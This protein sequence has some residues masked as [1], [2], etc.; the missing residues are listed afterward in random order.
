M[1]D[2]PLSPKIGTL[3]DG[4][5]YI[6][7]PSKRRISKETWRFLAWLVFW[8]AVVVVY[9]SVF[10]WVPD[11][12]WHARFLNNLTISDPDGPGFIPYG[13][14]PSLLAPRWRE[15]VLFLWLV[16]SLATVALVVDLAF[17]STIDIYGVGNSFWL[18]LAG[19]AVGDA[20]RWSRARK[21][22][23]Y[24]NDPRVDIVDRAFGG[25]MVVAGAVALLVLA[26]YFLGGQWLASGRM[27]DGAYLTC[28]VWGW[29]MSYLLKPKLDTK[30]PDATVV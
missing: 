23:S 18:W 14:L 16:V 24:L 12:F 22:F 19:F 27:V 17:T 20:L 21:L 25:I 8:L 26:N 13:F 10:R 28:F 2:N 6:T 15:K 4:R 1:S 3:P 30:A 9:F 11:T 7:F 29:I 5:S